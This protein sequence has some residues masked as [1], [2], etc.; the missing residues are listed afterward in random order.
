MR[1]ILIIGGSSSIGDHVEQAFKNH[2]DRVLSTDARPSII[3]EVVPGF[4][5][6]FTGKIDHC[7]WVADD[8]TNMVSAHLRVD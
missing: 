3:N 8:I 1:N 5:S 7:M 2:G 4:I 6:V